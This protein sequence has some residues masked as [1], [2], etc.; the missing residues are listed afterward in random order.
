MSEEASTVKKGRAS[1]AP[2]EKKEYK[3]KP[4]KPEQRAKYAINISDVKNVAKNMN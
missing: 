2:I 4:A 1:S 3:G